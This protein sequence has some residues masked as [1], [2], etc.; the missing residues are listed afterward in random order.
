MQDRPPLK[1]AVIGSGISGLSAAWLLAQRHAVTV[2]EA[3]PRLGGHSDTVTVEVGGRAVAVDTGFIVFNTPTYPNLTALFAHLGVETAASEMTFAVSLDDGALEYNGTDLNGLFAQRRNL[4]DP[5]FWAMLRDLVRFYRE[6]PAQAGRLGSISLGEFLDAQGYGR[7]FRDDHLLPMAAAIW[8][9]P[10][11]T[12]LD[13]PAESFIR[14]CENHGLLK[15]RDRPVWRTV[16]GGSQRYVEKL[17]DPAKA[18]F[19]TGCGAVRID[20][21]AAG[22]DVRDALGGRE[23]FDAV[24]LATHAD[25]A[26]RLICEP[27]REEEALLG[28]IR[29]S[30][31]RVILH[32]DAD[33]MPR[34]RRVWAS[35]NYAG[36]RA[37]AETV[38]A[39][40]VSYWM[41]R[42][43][44]LPTDHPL[45]VTLNPVRE[46][47][48]GSVLYK[49]GYEH[50]IF[51]AG[52]RDAQRDLWSIQGRRNT[53]FCG[54][55]FGAG[56]HEDGLQAG[57]AVAE[58]L[59]G[60]RRPWTVPDESGRIVLGDTRAQ[61]AS[62]AA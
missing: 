27:D 23:R 31:N 15:V 51:D 9:A 21:H 59:G 48:P 11:Q 43:Q 7:A 17:A 13:Y 22:A 28:A 61:T 19:R 8:S 37:R 25:T 45:F 24:V 60:M 16:K 57:L 2:Y 30:R 62:I 47:R 26:L 12:L 10:P 39:F 6:A 44:P 50:P 36:R 35:W 41:N 4:I 49:T 40:S 38:S 1:I 42:L 5:R 20:R 54:A 29:Y 55:H 3:A 32:D 56:F 33:L 46:P 58:A 34:R 52:A 14:F 18:R 53:W